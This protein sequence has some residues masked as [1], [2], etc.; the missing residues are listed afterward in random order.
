MPPLRDSLPQILAEAVFESLVVLRE[1]MADP[2]PRVAAWAAGLVARTERMIWELA[3]EQGYPVV[4]VEELLKRGA[5]PP[6]PLTEDEF[7]RK[8]LTQ[9]RRALKSKSD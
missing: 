8:W 6:R 5:I 9:Y 2:D 4:G 7:V 3:R 1:T